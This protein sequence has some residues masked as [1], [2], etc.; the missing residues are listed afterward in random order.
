MKPR[1]TNVT[2]SKP[3]CGCCGKPGTV[4][5]WYMRQPSIP[6]KSMPMSRPASEASGPI[7]SLPAGYTSRWCTQ[8]RNGS[9]VAH[10]GPSGTVWITE[11]PMRRGYDRRAWRQVVVNAS[12]TASAASSAAMPSS[13]SASLIVHGGTKCTRLKCVKGQTPRAL[14]RARNLGHRLRV[15]ARGVVGH[16]RLAASRGCGRARPPRTR[17]ARAPPPPT[18]DASPARAASGRSRSRRCAR[19]CSMMPSSSKIS[20]D[21]TA[22]AHASGWPEYVRPPGKG[23]RANVSAMRAR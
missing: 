21:A 19:A 18:D 1:R 7:A 11:S 23:C 4:A 15:G 22:D 16:E 17:R 13:T 14:H 6:A 3:R 2:V 9:T 20:I 12:A 10:W 8:N 5:P